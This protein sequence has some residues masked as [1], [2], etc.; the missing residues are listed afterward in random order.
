M[1]PIAIYSGS[2]VIYW[3]GL[4]I[5][6]G[7]AA[8]FLLSYSLYS[9]YY[10]RRSSMWAFLLF[11]LVFS[12]L[13]SRA[14]HYYCHAEQYVG[15]LDAISNYA[16]GGFCLPGVFFGVWLSAFLV[17]KVGLSDSFWRL[18]DASAPGMALTLSVIR[19]SSLFNSS[20]RGKMVISN[21]RL[22]RL[23]L[24]TT[25]VDSAGNTE[26]RFATFFIESIL[27][28]IIMAFMVGF[29]YSR[30]RAPM[31]KPE[32]KEGHIFRI[33][34]LLFSMVDLV[35]ASTRYDAATVHF[36]SALL[37][38]LNK[39]ASFI[40]IDMIFAAVCIL[41]LLIHYTKMSVRANGFKGWHVILLAVYVLSLFTVGYLGEYKVQR[42]TSEY[43]QRYIL[44]SI[45]SIG[46]A[47]SVGIMYNTC[48]KFKKK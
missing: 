14:L 13:L 45:G 44:M 43:L 7:I 41:C 35:C 20:C 27:L 33:F 3:S 29:F 46:M 10:C 26:Y 34:L 12:I 19:L 1:N 37:Q 23:P 17:Q 21:P 39:F 25:V 8:G 38:F 22:Q 40:K 18:L 5:V 32:K 47:V 2:I 9:A 48:V 11:S 15:F 36:K 6:L 31:K 42:Y 4:I 28:L 30:H 16:S 24:A